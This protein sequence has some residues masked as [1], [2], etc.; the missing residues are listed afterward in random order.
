MIETDTIEALLAICRERAIR[1]NNLFEHDDGTWQANLRCADGTTEFARG[2]TALEALNGALVNAA[3][4]LDASVP[5]TLDDL[6]A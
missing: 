3:V 2:G 6:L 5:S 1:V 4:H